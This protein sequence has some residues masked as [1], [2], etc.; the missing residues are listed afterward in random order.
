MLIKEVDEGVFSLDEGKS[1]EQVKFFST[2]ACGDLHQSPVTVV[3]FGSRPV[4]RARLLSNTDVPA[5]EADVGSFDRRG[6]AQGDFQEECNGNVGRLSQAHQRDGRISETSS[7]VTNGLRSRTAWMK[8]AGPIYANEYVK[9]GVNI[10]TVSEPKSGALG[11]MVNHVNVNGNAGCTIHL[12]QEDANDTTSTSGDEA[13]FV[14][15]V[16]SP[17]SKQLLHGRKQSNDQHYDGSPSCRSNTQCTEK[18]GANKHHNNGLIDDSIKL[19]SSLSRSASKEAGTLDMEFLEGNPSVL[20][21]DSGLIS[22][23]K[24]TQVTFNL[25]DEVELARAVELVTE[26]VEHS[27]PQVIQE[28]SIVGVSDA[29]CEEET[30]VNSSEI[31]NVYVR[32]RKWSSP[33]QVA[34]V[35]SVRSQECGSSRS[36]DLVG[37]RVI[38]HYVRRPHRQT[39]SHSQADMIEKPS[40]HVMTSPSNGVEWAVHSAQVEHHTDSS[41][42]VESEDNLN[43]FQRRSKTNHLS[44]V[45]N[46]ADI[47]T[48][49]ADVARV[50]SEGT[51]NVFQRR[52]KK[53]HL[54]EAEHHA[55]TSVRVESEG[56]FNV[57]QRR[58]KM[59]QAEHHAHVLMSKADVARVESERTLNVFQRRSKQNQLPEGEHQAN[60]PA[61]VE[62]EGNLNVFQRRSKK[63]LPQ[64]EPSRN[65]IMGLQNAV[66]EKHTPPGYVRADHQPNWLPEGW[67]LEIREGKSTAHPRD[68]VFTTL[69]CFLSQL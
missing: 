4:K 44:R 53:Y 59:N 35:D 48:P 55:D 36:E 64:K 47:L 61:R 10:K 12:M 40:E 68:K 17:T 60:V 50:E 2:E 3:G 39:D 18:L 29:G 54:P 1:P 25:P 8:M 15:Q 34:T 33:A 63:N 51:L 14:I 38:K 16:R 5:K 46:H 27:T 42:K 31:L 7:I 13:L 6:L 32:K 67:T 66:N 43:V 69:P 58:S 52:S 23:K 24:D 45:E 41:V 37:E 28:A 57:F 11:G 49:K 62:I 56:N 9:N 20:R 21:E 30:G 22:I 19:S 26:Q 65:D